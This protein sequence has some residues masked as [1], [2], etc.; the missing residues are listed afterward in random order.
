MKCEEGIYIRTG[1]N[2]K[3]IND[4]WSQAGSQRRWWGGRGVWCLKWMN[5]AEE[6]LLAN[7]W[8]GCVFP[9]SGVSVTAVKPLCFWGALVS[10][11]RDI[12]FQEPWG[13]MYISLSLYSFHPCLS[14]HTAFT[15]SQLTVKEAA[16]SCCYEQHP[17]NS[18]LMIEQVPCWEGQN[19]IA[20]LRLLERLDLK[21]KKHMRTLWCATFIIYY[22]LQLFQL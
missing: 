11:G 5:Y 14:A 13:Y 21:R 12:R 10:R 8:R 1:D 18:F 20:L 15:L 19:R 4:L 7:N 2:V 9:S 3:S 16:E 6:D 17:P 22:P